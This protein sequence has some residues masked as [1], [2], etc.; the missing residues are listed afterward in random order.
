LGNHVVSVTQSQFKM[1]SDNQ[2]NLTHRGSNYLLVGHHRLAVDLKGWRS[3]RLWENA[4]GP[5]RARL[6]LWPVT[7]GVS[8]STLRDD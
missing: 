5:F 2:A 8:R 6:K 1:F 3:R 7:W 4:D